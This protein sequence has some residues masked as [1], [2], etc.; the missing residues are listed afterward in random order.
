[1]MLEVSDKVDK[2]SETLSSLI[3]TQDKLKEFG[4]EESALRN[5]QN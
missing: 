1:M 2:H 4:E 5:T 3:Q